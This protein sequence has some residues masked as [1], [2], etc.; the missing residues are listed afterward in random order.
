MVNKIKQEPLIAL[1]IRFEFPVMKGDDTRFSDLQLFKSIPANQINRSSLPKIK[2]KSI[3][4]IRLS[5]DLQNYSYVFDSIIKELTNMKIPLINMGLIESDFNLALEYTNKLV[6]YFN[7]KQLLSIKTIINDW[8]GIS[9]ESLVYD[10]EDKEEGDFYYQEVYY[11]LI[12]MSE[13]IYLCGPEIRR[14]WEDAFANKYTSLISWHY[15]AGEPD[16]STEFIL[17]IRDMIDDK[18]R[19]DEN[20]SDILTFFEEQQDFLRQNHISPLFGFFQ[21]NR[22]KR[23]GGEIGTEIVSRL[24]DL[25]L[26]IRI[27]L[28]SLP[29]DSN[30]ILP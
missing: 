12:F 6:L 11:Q 26:G 15:E 10:W 18:L 8:P 16:K 22:S 13:S 27:T 5:T 14:L 25:G 28:N 7:H 3:Y 4:Y 29:P 17:S 20:Y 30:N 24:I 9:T 1:I 23:N 19:W 2:K 21:K